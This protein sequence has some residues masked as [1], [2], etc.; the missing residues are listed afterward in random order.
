MLDPGDVPAAIADAL[1]VTTDDAPDAL[2]AVIAALAL[3]PMLLV[4]DN[5]EHLLP[6]RAA[7]GTILDRRV[8]PDPADQPRSLD[9]D[10]ERTIPIEPLAVP[11]GPADLESAGS[12]RLFLR[13]AH[14]RGRPDILD[15][16]DGGAVVEICRRLDGMPLAIEL[17]AAWSR[18]LSPR[19]ILRRLDEQR[20]PLADD[21]RGR[22]AT[23]DR[24]LATTL[25]LL[26]LPTATRS[27]HS[28]CSSSGSTSVTPARCA[29]S[30]RA[31]AAP[32]PRGLRAR[33]VRRRR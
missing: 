27:S 18:V 26:R 29:A 21:D 3:H 11:D 14:E 6:A 10:G 24:V 25:D 19:A 23:M 28:R 16:L 1:A 4:L 12:S 5:F 7:V 33:P 17:A 22:Q 32:A 30:R 31:S 20:L 15:P 8:H 13:R 2:E 9:L